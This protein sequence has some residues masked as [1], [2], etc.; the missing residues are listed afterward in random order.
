MVKQAKKFGHRYPWAKWFARRG[1]I[2][3]QQEKDYLCRTDTMAQA[4]RFAAKRLGVAVHIEINE[5]GRS[6]SIKVEHAATD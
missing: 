6:L 3:L 4:A 2:I 5:N 1:K